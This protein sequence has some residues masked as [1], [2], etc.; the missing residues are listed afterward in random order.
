MS[1][2]LGVYISLAAEVVGDTDVRLRFTVSPP[3]PAQR[4]PEHV[5]IL[6]LLVVDTVV[7]ARRGH[8]GGASHG[9]A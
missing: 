3:H 5:T 8:D 2:P 1:I 7:T 9:C 4:C 6:L